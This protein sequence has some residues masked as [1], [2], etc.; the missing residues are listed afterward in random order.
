MTGFEPYPGSRST[1]PA[2]RRIPDDQPFLVRLNLSRLSLA[3]VV[4]WIVIL[5]P[6][7][8]LIA[9]F[10]VPAAISTALALI[11]LV[12]Y[13]ATNARRGPIL[14]VGPPGV[15]VSRRVRGFIRVGPQ[16]EATFLPWSSIERIY[17]R[18]IL[19]D[20]RVCVRE[21]GWRPRL[22]ARPDVFEVVDYAYRT[23]FNASLTFADRPADE[24]T[25]A[26]TQHGLGKTK[27][28]F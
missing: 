21:T 11:V 23:P 14:G 16:F 7:V 26:I 2:P 10:W 9:D 22:G 27:I 17:L 4:A 8:L 18:R 15:W 20:K 13:L 25:A 28:D 19:V 3:W 6:Q 5:G 1:Q 12:I 24:I